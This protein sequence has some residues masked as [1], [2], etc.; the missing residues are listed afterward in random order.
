MG[1]KKIGGITQNLKNNP[2]QS[3]SVFVAPYGPAC[4]CTVIAVVGFTAWRSA[5]L[6]VEHDWVQK[7]E[8]RR[9]KD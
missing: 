3:M 9:S 8:F 7:G 5:D 4:L 1:R 6:E 2:M